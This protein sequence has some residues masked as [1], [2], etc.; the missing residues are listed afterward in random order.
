MKVIPEFKVH[1]RWI[2]RSLDKKTLEYFK[3]NGLI[4][5]DLILS[6]Q[7]EI[8][9]QEICDK[10]KNDSIEKI[11]KG[12]YTYSQIG[13]NVVRIGINSNL[14]V[15]AYK[16]SSKPKIKRQSFDDE[17]EYE[18]AVSQMLEDKILNSLKKDIED[19]VLKDDCDQNIYAAF[20]EINSN[21]RKF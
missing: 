14:L 2:L 17:W 3:N 11:R 7:E 18:M 9:F 13:L 21:N 16:Y 19:L 5:D 10:I 8:Q 12:Q 4:F 1:S 15:D 20:Q 6:E